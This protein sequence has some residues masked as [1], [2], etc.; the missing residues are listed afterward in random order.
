[1]SV[2]C[3]PGA[4][5]A[6]STTLALAHTVDTGHPIHRCGV[7]SFVSHV[8]QRT[9]GEITFDVFPSGQLGNEQELAD[10]TVW[11]DLDVTQPSA[12]HAAEYFPPLSVLN[13]AYLFDGYDDLQQVADSPVGEELWAGL[14]AETGL[15]V[16]GVW[17]QGIRQVTTSAAPVRTPEDLRG[18]SLRAADSPIWVA[19]ALA[20]GA[21]PTPMALDE[22]YAALQQGVVQAQENPVNLIDSNSYDEVQRYLS[23]TD[24]VVQ[25]NPLVINGARW[26]SLTPEQQEIFREA[27]RISAERL[28][29]CLE[30]DAETITAGWRQDGSMEVIDDVD[31]EAFRDRA[32]QEVVPRFDDQW[33]GLY[34]RIRSELEDAS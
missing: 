23:L 17:P 3:A 9:G 5:P 13:A 24:H 10:N 27:G 4:G 14:R 34:Q 6:G 2:A 18:V 31:R 19:N 21:A 33:N 15:E 16:L 32:E 28:R 1:M 29:A 22:L 25:G 30:Q 20:L 26:A 11:G 8:E 12:G 7:E